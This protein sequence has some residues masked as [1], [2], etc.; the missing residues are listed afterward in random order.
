M[1]TALPLVAWTYVLG[2]WLGDVARFD[3]PTARGGALIAGL[4]F[5]LSLKR[6]RLR[7][8]AILLCALFVGV[9][10]QSRRPPVAQVLLDLGPPER[11]D[12]PTEDDPEERGPRAPLLCHGTVAAVP[13]QTPEGSLVRIRVNAAAPGAPDTTLRPG[14]PHAP[15]AFSFRTITPAILLQVSV[16]GPLREALY[17]GDPVLLRARPRS[18]Q[19]FANP[20]AP[21]PLRRAAA[22]GIQAVSSVE[23]AV[24]MRLSDDD[25]ALRA[26][27]RPITARLS[28]DIADL[29]TRLDAFLRTRL[30]A[31]P[32]AEGG[33][34]Y[35]LVASLVLG[36]R[37]ALSQADARRKERGRPTLDSTFRD[38]GIYHVLSV[39]GLHLAVAAYLFYRG[40]TFLLLRVPPLARRLPVR[41]LAAAAAL[42]ATLFYTLLT[43]AE[44]AT[45]RAACV[46]A[47]YFLAV[48]CGRRARLPEAL[49]AAALFLLHPG[50][51][52]LFLF[53]PSLQLSLAAALGT[54]C[55]RPLRVFAP[56]CLCAAPDLLSRT[57]RGALRLSEATV[58]AILATAPIC[59]LH[60]A[61]FQAA[62]VLG[63]LLAAPLGELLVVPLGLF[64][65]LLGQ[66]AP[67][68][69]NLLVSAAGASAL[70]MAGLAEE[71]AGLGLSFY[72]PAPGTMVLILYAAALLLLARGR[73]AFLWPLA[74]S[75]GLYAAAWLLPPGALLATFLDVGQ[76]DAAVVEAPGGGVLVIDAGGLPVPALPIS[77]DPFD[78]G[79][80]V[81]APYLHL[82]GHRHID[83]LIASHPHP[84]HIAG[85]AALLEAFTVGELWTAWPPE[86][87]A[88]S[89]GE[90]P[91]P[92]FQRLLAAAARRGVP[93]TRPRPLTIGGLHIQ[94]IAPCAGPPCAITPYT[95][96]RHNDNSLVLRL[97]YA[98]RTLLF[99]GDIELPG[100]LLL[101]DAHDRG[102]PV[103]ADLLKVPHHCSRT[104]S[105]E[106]LLREVA[107]RVAVCSLGLRNQYGFPAREVVA[108][109]QQAGVALFRTDQAGA[110][111][112]VVTPGGDLILDTTRRIPPPEAN[113][114]RVSTPWTKPRLSRAFREAAYSLSKWLRF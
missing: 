112:A 74:G 60:F 15:F 31:D 95:G 99:P 100:E 59:A 12:T 5:L 76:G 69:G 61:Q 2:I 85:M 79:E 24:L 84:D 114:I 80:R 23:P 73:R 35:A 82:R 42:P 90:H 72:V 111:Q 54:T 88:T 44:V 7:G 22:D 37:A 6:R 28:H 68:A 52:P 83:L 67:A 75:L 27:P 89:G 105:S 47:L 30:A 81:V 108:R 21:D 45:V 70:A 55:L 96:L 43:G 58:A 14:E 65:A 26:A 1:P 107:P 98:G 33:T 17:P 62:G 77:G 29:R 92:A 51:A 8:C 110:V 32:D 103:S 39:S 97:S 113:P 94:P 19:G 71:I 46:A 10:A 63:N 9:L 56:A 53:D 101:L 38:A 86:G 20:G 93:V 25:M 106:S 64:G 13:T 34:A 104:S 102:L 18:P 66:F 41:R 50:A 48:L 109:Y 3:F 49:A 16:R 4:L 91:D 11:P 36:E 87:P 40:L 57:A 78:P